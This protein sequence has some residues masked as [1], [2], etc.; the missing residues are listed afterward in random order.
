[1]KRKINMETPVTP[2]K[3]AH[4]VLRVRDIEKSLDWYQKVLG[5]S[6]VHDAGNLAFLTYDDEHHRLA[7]AKT[8]VETETVRGSPGL[9]HV[10]YTLA[11]L[12]E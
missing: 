12:G 7:L 3:F 4:F 11:T 9:D 10:A 6:I 2:A 8:P 1:M 5:M